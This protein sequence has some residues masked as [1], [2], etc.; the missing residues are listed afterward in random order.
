MFRVILVHIQSKC[1][2]TR[3][4]AI[5]NMDTFYVLVYGMITLV[6]LS[7]IFRFELFSLTHF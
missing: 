2:K 1:G 7:I 6:N 4:R 3:A 5:P